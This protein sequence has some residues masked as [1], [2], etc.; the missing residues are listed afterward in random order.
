MDEEFL[1]KIRNNTFTEHNI[2]EFIGRLEEQGMKLIN[3][4]SRLTAVQIKLEKGPSNDIEAEVEDLNNIVAYDNANIMKSQ[5]EKTKPENIVPGISRIEIQELNK[6]LDDL[7][8]TEVVLD[9]ERPLTEDQFRQTA[10]SIFSVLL[11]YF[12]NLIS[13][14]SH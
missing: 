3:K 5:L 14:N 2:N 12:L 4:F 13:F 1:S 8:D 10:F 9:K 7:I 11:D 6:I